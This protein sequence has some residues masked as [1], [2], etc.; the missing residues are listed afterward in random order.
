[1]SSSTAGAN[2]DKRTLI[3]LQT[4]RAEA[5]PANAIRNQGAKKV[6]EAIREHLRSVDLA[7]FVVEDRR[8]FARR[9]RDATYRLQRRLPKRAARR[10]GASR[11]ALNLFLR[12]CTY[13]HYLRARYG[14]GKIESWLEVPLDRY[15]AIALHGE[16]EGIELPRWQGLKRLNG[17]VSRQY[18]DVA[19]RVA[20][21]IPIPRVHL[22]LRY[23]L[24]GR[25][26]SRG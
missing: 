17:R 25:E 18:Q 22:D 4:F 20:D 10:W 13:D 15:V 3:L 1:M 9:L 16:P 2:L 6:L 21:R 12:D 14:L 5:I 23:W 19:Q 11:K 26:R 8:S 7:T 24:E